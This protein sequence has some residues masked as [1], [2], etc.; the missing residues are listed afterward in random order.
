[1]FNFEKLE[2]WRKS[3]EFAGLV[4]GLTRAFP[5][6]RFELTTQLRRTSVSVSSN[7]AEGCSRS[8]KI[9]CSRLVELAAGRLFEVISQTHTAVE[10]GYLDE[11]EFRSVHTSAEELG[12]TLSGL[13]SYLLKASDGNLST[14]NSQL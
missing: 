2:V 4:Y 6:E 12:R 1:M 14:L 11:Q 8:S 13:R 3:L 5:D 10:Q 9:D 7:I